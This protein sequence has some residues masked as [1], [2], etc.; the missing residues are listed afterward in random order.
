[1]PHAFF[2]LRQ[3]DNRRRPKPAP[4]TPNG[5]A[6]RAKRQA[7]V[8]RSEKS[9]PRASAAAAPKRLFGQKGQLVFKS[10]FELSIGH[11][12]GEPTTFGLVIRPSLDYFV[13]TGFSLGLALNFSHELQTEDIAGLSSVD[14]IETTSDSYG[15]VSTPEAIS[16]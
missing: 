6:T 11:T 5:T 16:G 10:D 9:E 12:T 4:S 8:A 7:D 1:M 2:E 15:S 3:R 13:T 14:R